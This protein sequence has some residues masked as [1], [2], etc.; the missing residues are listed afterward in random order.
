MSRAVVLD[1]ILVD[2]LSSTPF[3]KLETLV[4]FEM[5]WA[6]SRQFEVSNFIL[7]KVEIKSYTPLTFYSHNNH[8][9][10]LNFFFV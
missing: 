4:N 2:E 9:L 7:V 8:D 5:T 3:S 6:D 1:L 10:R